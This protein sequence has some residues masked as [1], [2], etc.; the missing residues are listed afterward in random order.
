MAVKRQSANTGYQHPQRVSEAVP[1]VQPIVCQGCGVMLSADK[2]NFT[3]DMFYSREYGMT[4]HTCNC[5]VC[6][7]LMRRSLPSDC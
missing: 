7:H 2:L 1:Q 4:T 6:N 5:P 3:Y